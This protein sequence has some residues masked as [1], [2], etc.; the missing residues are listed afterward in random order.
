M[1]KNVLIHINDVSYVTSLSKN[2][3]VLIFLPVM[4]NYS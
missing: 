3:M 2:Y 4:T 1:K